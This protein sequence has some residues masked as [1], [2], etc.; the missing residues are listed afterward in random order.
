[1]KFAIR[2][3]VILLIGGTFTVLGYGAQNVLLFTA[4]RT[5]TP[6]PTPTPPA[7]HDIGVFDMLG[8]VRSTVPSMASYVQGL[9]FSVGWTEIEYKQGQFDYTAI[10]SILTQANMTG[11]YAQL[12]VGVGAYDSPMTQNNCGNTSYQ[13]PPPA[14]QCSGWLATEGATGIQ[15][16][17]S[18]GINGA[19]HGYNTCTPLIDPDPT[20]SIYQS[21][22]KNMVQHVI[23]HVQGLT[24]PNVVLVS[25]SPFSDVGGNLSVSSSS[26]CTTT[27]P[28]PNVVAST[29]QGT[30]CY[31]N[32]QWAA[33]AKNGSGTLCTNTSD[34]EGC[35]NTSLNN[36]FSTLW[37]YETSV[38][39]GMDLAL[40]VAPFATPNI[41]T[42]S[43]N[44]NSIRNAMFAYA[45]GHQPA[46]GSAFIVNEAL[47]DSYSWRTSV[48]AVGATMG[49]FGAQMART[50]TTNGECPNGPTCAQ[51][52]AN[53][54]TAGITYGA[55]ATPPPRT[56]WQQ[57][58][59]YDFQNCPTQIQAI[60][61]AIISGTGC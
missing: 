53:L 18:A 17:S 1:M 44:D 26:G 33:I 29:S 59:Y 27:C 19:S 28:S 13:F 41:T 50:F 10:D 12:V 31:Y 48:S 30:N 6:T 15:V 23:S 25:I 42:T 52:C 39:N 2:A 45:A 5:A 36:V 46:S 4:Q 51:D 32:A 43:S 60:A 47:Q 56:N 3:F 22:W 20:N 8:T 55:C 54:Q 34:P 35:W 40:W 9:F 57:I 7:N 58:Y 21:E 16:W 11:H 49:G 61:N 37:N 38:S 14:G 24:N